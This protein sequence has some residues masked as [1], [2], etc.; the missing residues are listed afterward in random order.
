[1]QLKKSHF[2]ALGCSAGRGHD[3]D[4]GSF[5]P[6]QK[7]KAALWNHR[8]C[9]GEAS[10]PVNSWEHQ[11]GL[12]QRGTWPNDKRFHPDVRRVRGTGIAYHSR[13]R[14]FRD[15]ERQGERGENRPTANTDWRYFASL[16]PA[17]SGVQIRAA[18]YERVCACLQ[19]QPDNGVQIC[20]SFGAVKS[21]GTKMSPASLQ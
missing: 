20:C 12:H 19:S 15:A 11:C 6:C 5:L 13:A 7:H 14:P 16:S 9:E 3:S 8:T 4:F 10:A 17:S 2:L 21:R 18:K 1:M